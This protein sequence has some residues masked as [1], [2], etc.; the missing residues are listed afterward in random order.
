L[1]L[2]VWLRTTIIAFGAPTKLLLCGVDLCYLVIL[3]L[4]Y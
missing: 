3:V 2:M 4:L 1:L